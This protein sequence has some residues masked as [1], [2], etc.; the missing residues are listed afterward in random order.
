MWILKWVVLAL[1]LVSVVAFSGQNA[2]EI[3]NLRFLLWEVK[4]IPLPIALFDAFVAG[5]AIWFL[6]SASYTI[7]IRS[8][9]K[10][11]K[12]ENKALRERIKE[13]EEA[14]DESYQGN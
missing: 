7:Q 10:G 3:V 4:N 14:S 12:E 11:L 5:L 13:L 2:G 6:I 8:E 1:L 9:L